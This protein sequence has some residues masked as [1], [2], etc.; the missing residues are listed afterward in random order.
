LLVR[1]HVS[2]DS[3]YIGCTFIQESMVVRE[4]QKWFPNIMMEH[5]GTL[6]HLEPLTCFQWLM[7][8]EFSRF[9]WSLLKVSNRDVEDGVWSMEPKWT[10]VAWWI[11]FLHFSWVHMFPM[12]SQRDSL[13]CSQLPHLLMHNCLGVVVILLIKS[14]TR[15]WV[16]GSYALLFIQ[17]CKDF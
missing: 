11:K 1:L 13:L 4:F 2:D 7:Y 9:R 17:I 5:F 6:S 8:S 10:S 16:L 15:T 14:K 12:W 3:S